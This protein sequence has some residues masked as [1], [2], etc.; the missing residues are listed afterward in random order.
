MLTSRKE[1]G[2][3][4]NIITFGTSKLNKWLRTEVLAKKKYVSK[5]TTTGNLSDPLFLKQKQKMFKNWRKVLQ[6]KIDD[7]QAPSTIKRQLY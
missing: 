5:S 7:W 4:K 6:K 1:K 3:R 2:V